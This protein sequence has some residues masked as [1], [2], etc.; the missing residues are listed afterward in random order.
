MIILVTAFDPFGGAESNTSLEVLEALPDRIGP[1]RLEKRVLPTVFGK[2]ALLAEE[3]A[4]QLRP[5][6]LVCLGQAAGRKAVTPER[7]AVNLMD[8]SGPDNEG[9]RPVDE[10]VVP[11]GPAAYFSTLPV[12]AM[13]AAIREAGIPAA[14]S[15]TAG[16]FVCNSLMYAMLHYAASRRPD[17]LCGFVHVPGPGDGLSREDLAR[18][19]AAALRAVE[20][21][22]LRQPE[23]PAEG[24]DT[25]PC[26]SGGISQK[27]EEK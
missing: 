25:D 19:V 15:Y 26:G 22:K 1:A 13:A 21:S 24:T 7:V 5:D 10:P 11:G 3:A 6:A 8:A 14:V 4:E 9:N 20:N 27:E 18:G 2:A 16:T 12:K 23:I 17:L